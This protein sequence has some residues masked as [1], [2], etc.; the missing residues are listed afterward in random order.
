MNPKGK[1][2]AE[3]KQ[4]YLDM[5]Y[6]EKWAELKAKY[7]FNDQIVNIPVTRPAMVPSNYF[8]GE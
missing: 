6:F 1:T 7:E 3:L 4:K 2:L 5:G 8:M